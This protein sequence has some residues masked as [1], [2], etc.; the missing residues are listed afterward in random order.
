MYIDNDNLATYHKQYWKFV[1]ELVGVL[2]SALGL[3]DQISENIVSN[4]YYKAL[5]LAK[6]LIEYEQ[7]V[8]NRA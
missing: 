2:P 3:I 8:I 7:E 1:K 6:Q 5:K 4:H